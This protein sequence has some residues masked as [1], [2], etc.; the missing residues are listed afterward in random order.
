MYSR[1]IARPVPVVPPVIA[2]VKPFNSGHWIEGGIESLDF[3][4]SLY[5]DSERSFDWFIG[6]VKSSP[7]ED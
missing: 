5:E 1:M 3:G 6:V 7:L 4:S 2:A